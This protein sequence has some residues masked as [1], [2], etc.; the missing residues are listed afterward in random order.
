MHPTAT[1]HESEHISLPDMDLLNVNEV[2][3]I[4]GVMQT[5]NISLPA[6]ILDF[7]KY[8]SSKPMENLYWLRGDIERWLK[9]LRRKGVIR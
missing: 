4:P 2:Y 1:T 3:A 6:P 9:S 8:G 5:G 7:R